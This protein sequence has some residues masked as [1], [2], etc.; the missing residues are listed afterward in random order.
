MLAHYRL[1]LAGRHII[2]R[3]TVTASQMCTLKDGQW[4]NDNILNQWVEV[5][6]LH[7]LKQ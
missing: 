6:Q 4:L 5:L 7:L 1:L 2:N 3:N